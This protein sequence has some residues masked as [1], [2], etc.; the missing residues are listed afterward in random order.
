MPL[1]SKGSAD[2]V[3]GLLKELADFSNILHAGQNPARFLHA[4]H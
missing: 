1:L 2:G 4:L 3:H